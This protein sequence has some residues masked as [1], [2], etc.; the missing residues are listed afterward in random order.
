VDQNGG[1][2][3]GASIT[4]RNTA[5]NITYTGTTDSAGYFRLPVILVGTYDITVQ[6]QGFAPL[7]R[8]D[9][10]VTVGAR[11]SLALTLGVA[12]QT[13]K[14]DVLI[15]GKLAVDQGK[16]TGALAGRALR[17]LSAHSRAK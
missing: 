15:N 12:G 17:K 1:A 5:T 13:E 16:Y 11:L 4:A 3:A 9:V 14:V 8:K 2:V 7:V 10:D 6:A